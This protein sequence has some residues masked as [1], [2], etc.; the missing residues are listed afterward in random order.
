MRIRNSM[1]FSSAF[2]PHIKHVLRLCSNPE[3]VWINTCRIVSSWTVM[4]DLHSFWN[5]SY[6]KD[7]ANP[8]NPND[9]KLPSAS[10]DLAVAAFGYVASPKPAG[11][12]FMDLCPE[13]FWKCFGNALRGKIGWSNFS[14]HSISSVDCLPRLRLFVQR[15]GNFLSLQPN[16]A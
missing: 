1:W 6:V 2:S 3:M 10:L 14:L 11:I 16:V 12:C 4:M 13:A 7:V 5:W 9:S 8:V 15:A